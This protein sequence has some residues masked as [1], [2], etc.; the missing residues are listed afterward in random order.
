MNSIRIP[1]RIRKGHGYEFG[2]R[3][4]FGSRHCFQLKICV[5]NPGKIKGGAKDHRTEQCTVSNF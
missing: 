1:L 5:N 2:Y 3:F 4:E